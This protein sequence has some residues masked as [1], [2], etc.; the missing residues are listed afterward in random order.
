MRHNR[1]KGDLNYE[2]VKIEEDRVIKQNIIH[3][4]TDRLIYDEREEHFGN[5][6]RGLLQSIDGE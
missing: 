6:D 5:E 2:I 4:I 3:I 1:K